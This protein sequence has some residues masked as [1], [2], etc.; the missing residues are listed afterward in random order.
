MTGRTDVEL[1]LDLFL[2]DG[3]QSVADRVVD[4]AL[5]EIARTRQ[6]SGAGW[7]WPFPPTVFARLAA[8]VLAIVAIA[9]TLYLTAPRLGI[10]G[11]SVTPAPASPT[12]RFTREDVEQMVVLQIQLDEQRVGRLTEPRVTSV[13][14]LLPGDVYVISNT[15]GQ[16]T[17]SFTADAVAWA[18]EF[19]GTIITTRYVSGGT[20]ETFACASGLR[21]MDDATAAMH[22]EACR[23]PDPKLLST[24][25]PR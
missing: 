10:G 2:A 21:I 5:D 9:G 6:R 24:P 19:D 12:T 20:S 22:V 25:T 7:R 13:R 1:A 18:V 4:L 23:D 11:P 14:L 8:A 15:D 17:G 3:P 16:V